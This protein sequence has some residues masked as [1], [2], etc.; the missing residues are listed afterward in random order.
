MPGSGTHSFADAD[1]YQAGFRDVF[2]GFILT[3]A[4]VFD[5]HLSR[6]T[7][8]HLRLLQAREARSRVA[9]VSLP[10]DAV[11]ISFSADPALPLVWRGQT[12]DPGELM[13][14]GRGER[15]HQR[16]LGASCWGLVSLP[17][18]SLAAFAE[19]MTGH[20]LAPPASGQI[21]RPPTR[22]RKHLLRI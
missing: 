20:A 17:P 6:T 19:A 9:F 5:A 12:L 22:D 14:H 8:R 2:A 16:T 18:A 1:D 7:L 11:I 21:L 10:P 4:G 15:L 13:L 3:H